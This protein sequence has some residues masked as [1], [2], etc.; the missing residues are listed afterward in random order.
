MAAKNVKKLEV[1]HSVVDEIKKEK[2][3]W[4][5][6]GIQTGTYQMQQGECTS[7]KTSS[8]SRLGNDAGGAADE[9]DGAEVEGIA[10]GVEVK[11]LPGGALCR[12]Q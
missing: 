9:E 1:I 2:E 8:G 11:M 6:V 7:S 4:W 12:C 5:F 3:K 10:L